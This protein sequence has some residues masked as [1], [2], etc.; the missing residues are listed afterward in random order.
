MSISGYNWHVYDINW[1]ATYKQLAIIHILE[2]F[3]IKYVNYLL[4]I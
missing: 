1:H 4:I 2:V 3:G